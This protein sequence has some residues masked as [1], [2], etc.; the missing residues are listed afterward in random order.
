MPYVATR[1]L[2]LRATAIFDLC[3]CRA[4]GTGSTT[5]LAWLLPCAEKVLGELIEKMCCGGDIKLEIEACHAS[6]E[7]SSP[8]LLRTIFDVC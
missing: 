6:Q 1:R 8:V 3:Y 4:P 2:R 5:V 7:T